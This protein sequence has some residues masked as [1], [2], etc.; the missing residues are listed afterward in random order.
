MMKD[1]LRN[2]PTTGDFQANE[3]FGAYKSGILSEAGILKAKNLL[4]KS[5]KLDSSLSDETMS[6]RGQNFHN[7]NHTVM[8]IGW[9]V[10][11]DTGEKYWIVRNSYGP[12]WGDKGD[13]KLKRGSNDFG[14]EA[15]LMSFEPV[16]CSKEH[17]DTCVEI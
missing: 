13:F 16:L 9:G 1:I 7:W 10:D 15:N 6:K 5:E 11:K 2:G 14:M 12:F 3:Y 8:L 4:Q 17:H